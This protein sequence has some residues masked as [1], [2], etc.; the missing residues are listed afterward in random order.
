MAQATEKVVGPVL[1]GVD[2]E[3]VDAVI[4]AVTMDNPDSDVVVDDQGGYVRIGVPMR[5]RLTQ[6][7]LE[8]A[9][10]RPIRL[11]ELEPSLSAFA[12]RLKSGDDELLWYL[13]KGE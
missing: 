3:L 12:G 5:C 7:S 10:G 1:R 8:Q 13:E 2:S 4:D 6:A 9:L 11:S